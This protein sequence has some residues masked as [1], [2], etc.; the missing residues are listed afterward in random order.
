LAIEMLEDRRLLAGDTKTWLYYLENNV[1]SRALSD[2]TNPTALVQSSESGWEI[3]NMDLD[4]VSNR[5]VYAETNW[6]TNSR[7]KSV[8][9]LGQNPILIS[10][11]AAGKGNYSMAVDGVNQAVYL[12]SHDIPPLGPGP[13]FD[14]RIQKITYQGVLT[15]L[16]PTLWYVHDMEVDAEANTL[17]YTNSVNNDGL[18][19]SDLNG[20]GS[21]KIVF[22]SGDMRNIA[23]SRSRN[24]IIYSITGETPNKST[25]YKMNPDGTNKV[26]LGDYGGA[27]IDDIEIEDQ[28]GTIYFATT[29]DGIFKTS[30]DNFAPIQVMSGQKREIELLSVTNQSPTLDPINDLIIPENAAPQI[31]NLTGISAGENETQPLRVSAS[32]S[33]TYLIA[34]PT[35]SYTS[36]NPT[37]SINLVPIADRFGTVTITVTIA[38]AGMDG[39]LSTIADNATFSRSFTVTI[40]PANALQTA[41]ELDFDLKYIPWTAG[42]SVVGEITSGPWGDYYR[43]SDTWNTYGYGALALDRITYGVQSEIEI[44]FDFRIGD[45]RYSGNPADGLAV[46]LVKTSTYGTTGAPSDL[47]VHPKFPRLQ[48][49]LIVSLATFEERRIKIGAASQDWT[50]YYDPRLEETVSGQWHHWRM[51]VITNGN[52]HIVNL[53]ITKPNGEIYRIIDSQRVTGFSPSETRVVMFSH[54]GATASRQEFDN[55][56]IR[57]RNRPPTLDTISDRTISEDAPKQTVNLTGITA[58]SGET[59]P[60]RLT[61]TSSNTAL[62][63]NPTVD[64]TSPNSTGSI[65]FAPVADRFGTAT[66]TITIED[67]GIDGN[68]DTTADNATFSRSFTIT[69]NP[70]NDSPTDISL[71]SPSIAENAGANATVGFL[72]TTD[73]DVGDTFT[74]SLVTGSGDMDNAAFNLSGA[75]LRANSSFDFETKSS[76]SIRVRSTDQGGL[77]TEKVFTISVTDVLEGLAVDGTAGVDTILATYTGD[78]TNHAWSIKLNT[79]APFSATGPLLVNGLGGND[80]LQ[81]T[82][83]SLSDLFELAANQIVVNGG[84]VQFSNIET[85][86]ILGGDGNDELTVTASAPAGLSRSF[87]GGLGIDTVK[88]VAGNNT[89]NITGAGIANLTNTS[90]LAMTTTESLEGGSGNDQFVYAAA[91]SLTGKVLGGEGVDSI[92]FAAKTTAHTVN[93]QMNTSTSTGGI[94]GIESFIGSSSA[95]VTDVL[96]GANSSTNWT[97]DGTNSGSLSTASGTNSFSNFESLTGG[98]AADSFTFT[99]TGSLSK[100][101]TGGTATGIID[102]LNLS[103]KAGALDF[104]L[105]ATTNTVPGAILGNY[106]GIEQI[107]GNSVAGSQVTRVNNVA[108]AWSVNTSGQI[109]VGGVT[110]SGVSMIAGNLGSAA[111]TLTGP[112]VAATWNVNSANAGTLTIPGSTISFSHIENVT[113]S[114]GIDTFV[115]GATGSLSGK[116]NGGTA[117]G[118]IDT[119]NLSAKS[120]ALNFQL[121]TTNSLPGTIG[122]YTGIEQITGNSVAGSKVTRVNNTTTAWTINTSGQIVVSS[123]KYIAVGG[124][125][126]GPGADTI[127]G[128]AVD[129]TWT[130]NAANGGSLAISGTTIGFNG[131][132][133][134]AGGTA[135]DAFAMLAG[136]SLTGNLNGG[137]GTAINS[138]SYATWTTGVTVNLAVTT[139]ANATSIAG[140]TSNIQMVTGGSGNDALT[141]QAAKATILIGLSGNDTLI[142]GSQRD[143][144]F[145]GTGADTLQSAA[146]DDLLIAGTTAFDS[147]RAA[148]LLIY[149]EWTSTRTFAQRTANLWGNGTGTRANGSTF[150]NNDASDS[151]TDTVFADSEVDRLT[152]GLGQ[153]WF[154]A[155]ASEL[156]DFLGTGTTPDRK[157]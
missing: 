63:P 21:T 125:E 97:I 157:N 152:G 57:A 124:I 61:A 110:Y 141:G 52:D 105:N 122:T 60:L 101:L 36:S 108:T 47:V 14:G 35:V 147:N 19:K 33:D 123:V 129:S 58:G 18:F 149:A 130:I 74:Y 103:A 72:S 127:T 49:G 84:A 17:Y 136:G 3:T 50:T 89:W 32:S 146:A 69:V 91:G 53:W 134:L 133:N 38:D 118:G 68:L 78:G 126:G 132:E 62:I 37:G 9:L 10:Q 153:D 102:T 23:I 96:I 22:D 104:R 115:F 16:P 155:L 7:I 39:D 44:E 82:G 156:T 135:S 120:M 42:G 121:D 13:H 67:G 94:G 88:A 87:D 117:T 90:N 148:I 145:G 80:T 142:G 29:L 79:A 116:L 41:G 2:G 64:Y 51:N 83:R 114:T 98:I 45:H 59:Q 138:L 100:T 65:R 54:T 70:V 113:G 151:I 15:L 137:T 95:T 71:S 28:T 48:D 86:K 99:N 139:L 107:T 106:T 1:I 111:D 31:V 85:L 4:I 73:I 56:V 6:Q 20:N 34:N 150:L 26:K 81:I 109:I 92:S 27:G 76:Y 66:I 25:I 77:W 140:L 11:G 143:L 144:L 8:D 131:V 5:I 75:T 43:M 93:L 154:F 112:A 119:L 128:P 55:L 46:G 40:L 30:L 24:Q 12:H